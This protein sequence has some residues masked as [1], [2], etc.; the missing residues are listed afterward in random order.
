MI[1]VSLPGAVALA[2]E[3][4]RRSTTS[5][6]VQKNKGRPM[7]S[8]AE[9]EFLTRVGPA[10]T[11]GAL[12]RQYWLPACLS[13]ELAADGDPLRLVLPASHPKAHSPQI[14]IAELA[15]QRHCLIALGREGD[16]VD[17][18]VPLALNTKFGPKIFDMQ[19]GITHGAALPERGR[20]PFRS[21]ICEMSMP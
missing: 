16:A 10:T 19:D 11:M 20:R 18:R 12:M 5:V 13:S 7:T 21:L 8:E 2:D 6:T 9:T 4:V 3:A 1:G 17:G 15:D 14:T